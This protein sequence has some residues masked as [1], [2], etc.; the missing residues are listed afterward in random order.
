MARIV[1]AERAR[2]DLGRLIETHNL[3]ADTVPRVR[4]AIEPLASFPL[5]GKRLTGRWHGFR[6]VLG[7]WSWMLIVYVHD[8]A[9]DTIGVVAIHDARSAS[10]ATSER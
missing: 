7:P 5:M 1:V 3:P 6:V 2:T 10:S 4:A 8:V 9:T